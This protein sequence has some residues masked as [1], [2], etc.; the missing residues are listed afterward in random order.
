MAIT[1]PRGFSSYVANIGVKDSS[2]DFTVVAADSVCA[3]AGVF[4]QSSFAGPSVLVSREHLA[5]GTARAMVVI[6][7]NANVATG[8]QG[9]ADAR[10]VVLTGFVAGNQQLRVNGLTLGPDGMV[11]AANGRNGGEISSPRRPGLR[12]T[13]VSPRISSFRPKVV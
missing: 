13:S 5:S 9:L 6:S 2:K 3:A 4:T 11:Y 12:R 10:E 1:L 7:K 8:A